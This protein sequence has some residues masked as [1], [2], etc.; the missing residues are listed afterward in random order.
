VAIVFSFNA[1]RSRS[2]WQGFSLRWWL[3]EPTAQESLLYSP[4]LRSAIIQSL[5]LSV[6]TA[7]IAVPIGTAFAIGL[8]RW[9]GRGSRLSNFAMLFSFVIPELILGVALY[10]L[11]TQLF[12]SVFRELGTVPQIFGLVTVQLAFPVII[13]RAR[14]LSIPK[15]YGEAAMDLGASPR[16][17]IRRVLLPLLWPAILGS[18]AIVFANSIDDFVTVRA[19]SGPADSEPLSVKIYN[20]SRTAPTPAVNAA[21]TLMLVITLLGI[22]LGL[23]YVRR[24]A[25]ARRGDGVERLTRF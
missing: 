23:V 15:E 17:S 22:G 8:D 18:F 13:V 6:F 5:R 14:L 24:F 20:A 9:R 19:L 25:R 3:G 11:F 21:A 16:E 4:D 12:H 2:T 7:V 10:L 1:G